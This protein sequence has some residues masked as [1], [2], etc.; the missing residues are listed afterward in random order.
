MTLRGDESP[1]YGWSNRLQSIGK[2]RRLSAKQLKK[3]AEGMDAEGLAE[4]G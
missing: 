1:W 3:S 4:S 2:I